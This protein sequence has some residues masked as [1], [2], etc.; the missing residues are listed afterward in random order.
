LTLFTFISTTIPIAGTAVIIAVGLL[1]SVLIAVTV[2]RVAITRTFF[3]RL[4]LF[5]AATLVMFTALRI[6]IRWACG[7]RTRRTAIAIVTALVM[8][9]ALFVG[10]LLVCRAVGCGLLGEA[11]HRLDFGKKTHEVASSL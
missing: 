6:P 11:K 5:I 4:T 2:C 10:G 9:T 7:A 3:A 1:E 8:V